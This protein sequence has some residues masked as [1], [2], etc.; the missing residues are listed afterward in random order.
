[1]LAAR[2][3]RPGIETESCAP[4]N[5]HIARGRG[6]GLGAQHRKRIMCTPES[7]QCLRPRLGA[8]GSGSIPNRVH[9]EIYTRLVLAARGSRHSIENESCAPVIGTMLCGSGSGLGARARFP[10]GC[11]PNSSQRPNSGLEVAIQARAGIGAP[12]DSTWKSRLGHGSAAFH[13]SLG[14]R[15]GAAWGTGSLFFIFPLQRSHFG[16]GHGVCF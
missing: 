15:G 7:A 6:S 14:A 8:R 2:G 16:L 11:T 9:P 3:S 4:R 12:Q 5:R 1:M 10:I 13:K